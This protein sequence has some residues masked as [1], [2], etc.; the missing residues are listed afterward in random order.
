M[1]A[2]SD[3]AADSAPGKVPLSSSADSGVGRLPDERERVAVIADREHI[4]RE[5]WLTRGRSFAMTAAGSPARRADASIQA[6]RPRDA[7]TFTACATFAYVTWS[8][9]ARHVW[10][11]LSALAQEVEQAVL[12]RLARLGGQT[13]AM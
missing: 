7:E 1:L 12:Y 4:A 13:G 5:P 9:P 6:Q 8:W 10:Q 11:S 3:G 2:A